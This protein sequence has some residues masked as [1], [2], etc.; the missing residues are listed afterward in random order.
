MEDSL[1]GEIEQVVNPLGFD[2]VEVSINRSH[3]LNHV[4]VT[5]H[6]STG[7][8]VDDCTR[9]SR[10]IRPRLEAIYPDLALEVSSPGVDRVIKSAREYE[11]FRDRGVRILLGTEPEWIGGTIEGVLDDAV[12]LRRGGRQLRLPVSEIRKARLDPS[13]EVEA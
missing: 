7:V 10:L 4:R 1:A 12:L 11:I 9:I 3:R 2:V 6:R 8:G 5:V 13:Q